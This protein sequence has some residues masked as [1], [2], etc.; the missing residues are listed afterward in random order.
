MENVLAHKKLVGHADNLVLAVAVEDDD[1]VDVGAVADVLVLLQ[2]RT[3]ETVVAV[4]VE[5]LV[6]LRHLRGLDGVEAA[7]LCQSRVVLAVFVLEELEPRGRH[8]DEVCQVAVY[9][10]DLGL[11]ACHQ[12]VGLVLVELQDSLHLD[13]QQSQDVVLRHLA[14]ECGVV[15]RQP[16]VDMFANGVDI[17]CLFELLVLID[18]LLDEYLLQRAEMQLL[19][20]FALANLQFL[21]DE[22]FRAVYRV[23]QHVADGQELRLMVADDAAVGRYVNLAVGKGVERVERLVRRDAGG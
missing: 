2:T 12:F 6:S 4:D 17:R 11:D 9:L 5:L 18:T 10:V 14:D 23:S 8:L 20:Q 16:L 19:L 7:Y 13:F 1:V 3:D 21:A 22:V 15:G